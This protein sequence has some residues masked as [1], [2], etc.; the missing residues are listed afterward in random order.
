ML[1]LVLK[2]YEPPKS[3]LE[4]LA[5]EY[6]Q[7]QFNTA[8]KILFLPPYYPEFNPI[9]LAWARIKNFIAD[10]PTYNLA[11]L[12][13]LLIESQKLIDSNFCCR[14][15]AHCFDEVQNYMKL[16]HQKASQTE[17]NESSDE[18]DTYEEFDDEE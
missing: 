18:S 2:I 7:K 14:I 8:H 6:G 13:N 12:K 10:N 15:F 9:E 3:L 4:L 5:E 1:Q 17:E 11:K 16:D